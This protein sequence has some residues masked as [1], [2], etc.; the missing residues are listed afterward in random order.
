MHRGCVQLHELL[1]IREAD[2]EEHS[3]YI[4]E[5]NRGSR[6]VRVQMTRIDKGVQVLP[7]GI[8]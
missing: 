8:A 1:S 6:W 5:Q 7:F 2:L 3:C 4:P